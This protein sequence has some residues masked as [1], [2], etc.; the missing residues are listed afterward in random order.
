M[1]CVKANQMF[2]ELAK[3]NI[4]EDSVESVRQKFGLFDRNEY[5]NCETKHLE[6]RS[7]LC[8]TPA[9]HDVEIVSVTKAAPIVINVRRV[10]RVRRSC[11]VKEE[12]PLSENGII[13]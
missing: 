8:C 12:K 7:D 4:S 13:T 10:R 2:L 1:R 5:G 11:R 3:D 6:E 9:D